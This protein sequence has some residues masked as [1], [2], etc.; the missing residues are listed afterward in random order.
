MGSSRRDLLPFPLPFP[1][2]GNLPK[3]PHISRSIRRKLCTKQGWQTWANDGAEATNELYG[4]HSSFAGPLTAS[5]EAALAQF[6]NHYR[7]VDKPPSDVSPAGAF[8]ELCQNSLPYL[9]ESVGP[10]PYD[11][12]KISLPDACNDP[13]NPLSCLSPEHLE[14]ISGPGNP[15]LRP[16]DE[17]LHELDDL[18]LSH[19]HVD[20]A[21]NSPKIYVQFLMQMHS[22]Q[23]LQFT[24]GGKTYL[25]VFFVT[26]KNG[27][28]R[29]ILDTRI[30]NCLFKKPPKTRLPTPAAL[31]SLE[32]I[33]GQEVYFA[34]GD[35]DNCFYRIK[36]PPDVLWGHSYHTTAQWA[37]L[38]VCGFV[39]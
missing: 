2:A 8:L 24:T 23:L 19:A 36:A 33:A 27:K 32:T 15:M 9:S 1:A 25:G 6:C 12:E 4:S 16:E 39:K 18:G 11:N 3:G 10:A 30:V 17:A 5:K 29:V 28:L 20:P 26:K 13:A 21:F 7:N 37:G 35:I 14:L 31:T 38:G 22:R 34:G